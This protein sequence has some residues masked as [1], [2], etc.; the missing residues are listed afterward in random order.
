[1]HVGKVSNLLG[2]PASEGHTKKRD[3]ASCPHPL[4]HT[5]R[6]SEPLRTKQPRVAIHFTFSMITG[7]PFF[8]YGF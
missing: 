5:K 7:N 2:T 4:T 6:E 1:M 3:E 8:S